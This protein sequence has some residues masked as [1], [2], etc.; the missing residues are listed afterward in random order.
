MRR[1]RSTLVVAALVL[2]VAGMAGSDQS[3]GR[4]KV[5]Q[6]DLTAAP[7]PTSVHMTTNVTVPVCC[8][9]DKVFNMTYMGCEPAQEKPV[10]TF[11][12]EDGRPVEYQFA[13][14][15]QV[16]FPN[17]TSYSLQPETEPDD[18][19]YL[20]PDGNLQMSGKGARTLG[21]DEFCLLATEGEMGAIVCF[22]ASSV[23]SFD[24]V[25]YQTLYPVGLII[26]AVFLAATL[27]VYCL[28]VEL[29][30]LLG[31]C[32]MCSILALCVAQVST[33]I[34][35]MATQH[36]S[37]NA[38]IIIA[39]MMHFWYLSAFLWLNVISF[40]V[41]LTIWRK[42]NISHGHLRRWF[43][44][45]SAYAWGLSLLVCS[46]AV[47]RDFSDTLDDSILPKP[48]FGHARC[49]FSDDDALIMF[50]YGP[51]SVVLGINVILF[52]ASAFKLCTL[53]KNSEVRVFQFSLYFKLFVLMGVTWIFEVISYFVQ[54][55]TNTVSGNYVWLVFDLINIMQGLIIFAVFVCRRAVLIRVCEV[56]CGL[57]YSRATFPSYYENAESDLATNDAKHTVI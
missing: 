48:G 29:R 49:W 34:V 47:A 40:N 54:R 24:R 6:Q 56:L 44:V 9:V 14:S 51:T 22:P 33:V 41:C 32:L 16:G 43:V 36:L 57:S 21:T 13:Y 15:V 23:S 2:A 31:R 5:S 10:I 50:F 27:L 38:C 3:S 52:C 4:G 30:D 39:V 18:A 45:Y 11:H 28:V 55:E 25:V 42:T 53:S 12:Y 8:G 46:L 20:L 19:F 35:Q 17:C 1:A 26:S 37:M 7:R